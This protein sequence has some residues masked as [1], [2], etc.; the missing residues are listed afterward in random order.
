MAAAVAERPRVANTVMASHF[1][2]IFMMREFD[3]CA[4]LN[5][6]LE[7]LMLRE[8][9]PAG[10]PT[11]LSSVSAGLWFTYG[12]PSRYVCHWNYDGSPGPAPERRPTRLFSLLFGDP[13][14]GANV[15]PRTA[16]IKRSILDTVVEEYKFA[17]S[18][19][20]YLG[21]ESKAKLK[22]HLDGIRNVEQRLV[23][24]EAAPLPA[25][26]ER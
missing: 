25:G 11:R 3:D 23:P 12:A 8:L 6:R 18:D 14:P 24:T 2:T 16:R 19:R 20:S 1:P 15:D 5:G 17:I 26:I 22:I 7:Q 13:S 21:A 10:A 9:H 4:D